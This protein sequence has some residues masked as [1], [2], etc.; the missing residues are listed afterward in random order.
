MTIENKIKNRIVAL[1]IEDGL[2]YNEE[3]E[4]IKEEWGELGLRGYGI[5][6]SDDTAL[7]HIE[8]IDELEIYDGD[9]E[10]SRQAEKDG[11]KIIHDLRFE[12]APLCYYNDTILDT[13]ENRKNFKKLKKYVDMQ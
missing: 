4:A 10:A 9:L 1:A 12:T 5:F 6:V 13:K 11:I 3:C 7:E 8:R 2:S